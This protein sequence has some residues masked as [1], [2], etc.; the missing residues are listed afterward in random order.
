MNFKLVIGVVIT[1]VLATAVFW[2]L[3]QNTSPTSASAASNSSVNS[4]STTPV[5]PQNVSISY[6]DSDALND[7]A[8][9][10][11]PMAGVLSGLG[12]LNDSNASSVL[13]SVVSN[14]ASF[15]SSSNLSILSDKGFFISYAGAVVELAN[16]NQDYLNALIIQN[17]QTIS[18]NLC[19]NKQT[20]LRSLFFANKSIQEVLNSS[21]MLNSTLAYSN[22]SSELGV[23][24]SVDYL[25][26]FGN[27]LQILELKQ[28]SNIYFICG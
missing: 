21:L 13:N 25:Q 23:N 20:Y 11:T 3:T 7:L 1:V 18:N 12:F 4:S 27:E 15:E 6:N 19:A 2:Y 22:L 14:L 10:I 28:E 16:A 5:T 9:I 26:I 8:F 24:Y 17:N